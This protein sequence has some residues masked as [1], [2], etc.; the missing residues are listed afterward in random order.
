MRATKATFKLGIQFENWGA[1]G[2]RY[3]H[4]VGVVGRST[5]MANF[6]HIWLQARE[7]GIASDLGDY[8]FE[9]KAAEAA[10]F[11]T[12]DTIWGGS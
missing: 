12:S 1:I 5:W 10:R 11:A 8:C 9:L 2:D 6:H 4:S 7:F 3:I